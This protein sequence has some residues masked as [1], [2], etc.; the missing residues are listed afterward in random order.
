MLVVNAGSSSIKFQMFAIGERDRLRRLLKG[1]GMGVRQ[2]FVAEG[3][4]GEPPEKE[5]WPA[6][7]VPSIPQ[8]LDKLIGFLRS[9]LERLPT[10]LGH[11]V[12]HG[13]PDY[14]EPVVVNDTV[15]KAL[16]AF[17]PLALL[18]QPN[19]LTPIHARRVRQPQLLQVA[20]FATAFH[21]GHPEVAGHYAIPEQL[22]S[23][24]MRRC[25]FHGVSY[26]YIAS[27]TA[28]ISNRKRMRKVTRSFN[29]RDRGSP[30]TAFPPTR[31]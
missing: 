30:A 20:C 24:G 17:A 25:G 1:E 2:R 23:E 9:R 3:T 13:G 14:A 29:A 28:L 22:C 8:A 18:H 19:N 6:P 12:V 10:A 11:R 4:G 15:L 5:S 21:R 7:E 31:S 16:D 27:R 26:E